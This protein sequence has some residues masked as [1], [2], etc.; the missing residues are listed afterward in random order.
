MS[1]PPTY[2][3]KVIAID[4][5]KG[6]DGRHGDYSALVVLG[7]DAQ[8]TAYVEANL[9]RRDASEI[10]LDG[11]QMCR[12]HHANMLGVEANQFQ[13]LLADDFVAELARQGLHWC[14][15]FKL[16]N[17]VPKKVRIR[18]IG[19]WLSRRAMRFKRGCEST[20]LLVNQLRD[21]PLGS[22]DDGPDAL[23]MALRLVE[24]HCH[25]HSDD[26]LG[27]RLVG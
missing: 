14:T 19:S 16:H 27:D 25:G 21:F 8:G 2:E 1:G 6:G 15:L 5:S 23:E 4:P 18:R 10:V 13:E 9:A 17:T 20:Q 11:V 7:I 24:E 12:T 22:H 26:G 3:M